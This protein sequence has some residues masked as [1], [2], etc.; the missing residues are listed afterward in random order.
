MKL[1]HIKDINDVNVCIPV[2]NIAIIRSR[3]HGCVITPIT[4]LLIYTNESYDSVI[5]K[6]NP[7]AFG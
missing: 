5:K 4:G 1:L 3:H 2:D 6:I 7:P